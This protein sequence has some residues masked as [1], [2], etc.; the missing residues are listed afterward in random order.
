MTTVLTER[1]I[2]VIRTSFENWES[3]SIHPIFTC[4]QHSSSLQ[5]MKTCP[6]TLVICCVMMV[7]QCLFFPCA[8][9]CFV[10]L[11]ATCFQSLLW[12]KWSSF[13]PYMLDF[14][15]EITRHLPEALQYKHR[16]EESWTSCYCVTEQSGGYGGKSGTRLTEFRMAQ[17]VLRWHLLSCR[18]VLQAWTWNVI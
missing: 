6:P 13:Y 3:S 11:P 1:F 10:C 15:F 9:F 5:W 14:A 16:R 4:Q 8:C 12:I 17:H 7:A 2:Q 18:F